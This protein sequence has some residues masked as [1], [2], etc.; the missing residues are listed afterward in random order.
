MKSLTHFISDLE[1]IY[2]IHKGHPLS[3]NHTKVVEIKQRDCLTLDDH[4]ERKSNPEGQQI[5]K[6]WV[7][8]VE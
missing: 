7:D 3:N 6:G 4:K 5:F 8:V 2:Q 1:P